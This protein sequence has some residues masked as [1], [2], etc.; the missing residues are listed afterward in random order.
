[1]KPTPKIQ[2][3][4]TLIELMIVVVIVAI[5][6]AV[7][8]PSFRA[9]GIRTNRVAATN[10]LQEL[11][12]FLERAYSAQGRYDDVNNAGALANALPFS[13]SPRDGGT[14]QYNLSLQALAANTFVLR[15]APAN[16]QTEDTDCGELRIDEAGTQCIQAGAKCSDSTTASVRDEVAACW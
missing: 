13:T 4:F 15:A 3:G 11:T 5:I 9:Y 1:M 6:A 16:A 12:M 8:L 14:T 7:A 2:R 10:D